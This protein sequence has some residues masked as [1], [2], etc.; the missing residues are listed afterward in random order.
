[1]CTFE[2]SKHTKFEQ[3][4]GKGNAF[5]PEAAETSKFHSCCNA[6]HKMKSFTR[7]QCT[8]GPMK[9]QILVQ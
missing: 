7:S 2:G 5:E 3:N 8:F 1:M 6:V 9:Q 4:Q